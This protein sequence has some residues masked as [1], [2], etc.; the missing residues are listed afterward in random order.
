M[1]P[2]PD[3]LD[4]YIRFVDARTANF[5]SGVRLFEFMFHKIVHKT[6]SLYRKKKKTNKK[7]HSVRARNETD[8]WN[9]LILKEVGGVIFS[10]EN[11]SNEN[12]RKLLFGITFFF[13]STKRNKDA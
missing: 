5:L 4:F 8:K 7:I 9:F 11:K 10:D 2:H 6:A 3:H 12:S 13:L 1:F